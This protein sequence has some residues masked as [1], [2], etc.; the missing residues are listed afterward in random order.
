M[1]AYGQTGQ[2]THDG[3]AGAPL[4]SPFAPLAT[5]G[6][7][8]HLVP[9][10]QGL[11]PV[12][13]G[14]FEY[15]S[16][17]SPESVA[18][19]PRS[20][21]EHG[22]SQAGAW[23][24]PS[25]EP[26][27][28][29]NRGADEEQAEQQG[30]IHREPSTGEHDDMF[31]RLRATM[32]EQLERE[33]QRRDAKRERERRAFEE[34]RARHERM[35]NQHIQ[36]LSAQLTQLTHSMHQQQLR[37]ANMAPDTLIPVA[38]DDWVIDADID[39]HFAEQYVW[40]CPVT[41]IQE[42]MDQ[43]MIRARFWTYF[44]TVLPPT[45][46]GDV[47][48]LDIR[49]LYDRI[50]K[51]DRADVSDQVD[52]LRHSLYNFTKGRKSMRSWLAELYNRLDELAK[53][54]SPVESEFVRRLIK[55]SLQDHKIYQDL[56]RDMRKN[57]QWD[58][59]TLRI[60]LEEAARLGN[61]LVN[62]EPRLVVVNGKP[63]DGDVKPT[64]TVSKRAAKK[65]AREAAK[66]ANKKAVAGSDK[67][68]GTQDK[69]KTQ[70]V[71]F[72]SSRP[73]STPDAEGEKV[74][75]EKRQQL[76]SE[77]CRN[78]LLGSC[79]YGDG[80]YR[81]HVS[82]TEIQELRK[83][84]KGPAPA[85]NPR[86]PGGPTENNK[87]HNGTEGPTAEP[88]M[89]PCF[90]FTNN[91]ACSYGD[92]CKFQHPTPSGNKMHRAKAINMFKPKRGDLVQ[93]AQDLI[94]PD[95]RGA[96]GQVIGP[97]L[98][99]RHRIQIT[100]GSEQQSCATLVGQLVYM[101]AEVG[102]ADHEFSVVP[103]EKRKQT[104]RTAKA[105]RAHAAKASSNYSA[106]AIFDSGA[107]DV[108][109][110][111]HARGIFASLTELDTPLKCAGSNGH[112]SLYTHTGPVTLVTGTTQRTLTGYYSE[113]ED[114]TVVPGQQYDD[115]E[116]W[117]ASRNRS[118]H[119]YKGDEHLASFPRDIAIDPNQAHSKPFLESLGARQPDGTRRHILYPLPDTFFVWHAG[120][121]SKVHKATLKST[122]KAQQRPLMK[123]SLRS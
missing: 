94:V 84:A 12:H 32:A 19:T 71:G 95:L 46:W 97:G 85:A 33:Q 28:D 107:S 48:E 74:D 41:G 54:R 106:N 111:P 13:E 29:D 98:D 36:A 73:A 92:K 37:S 90:Q 75:L 53:L 91:G 34:A 119:L 78:F 50:L 4:S 56:L 10:T 68:G 55:R 72:P 103:V 76:S 1:S 99:G 51:T 116:Y 60:H 108:F 3:N 31:E 115:C 14:R 104:L 18:S 61:D 16:P 42:D 2:R 15:P 117:N 113:S 114:T 30:P 7:A 26:L 86:P 24:I 64:R 89:T 93:L 70:Q 39:Y 81:S 120:G 69:D 22:H 25:P 62:T 87:S 59:P 109:S 5:P 79:R 102:M 65:A 83:N 20:Q 21:P 121:A 17:S 35:Q 122:G 11:Q 43:S 57:P 100:L 44:V 27:T 8:G 9:R 45:I 105:Y 110:G 47:A 80:C 82:F 118:L 58:I 52:A 38:R 49:E 67:A 66:A 63:I 23:E 112:M 123:R 77:M 40:Y 101:A 88:S 6:V 96:L